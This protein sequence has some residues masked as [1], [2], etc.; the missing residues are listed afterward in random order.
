MTHYKSAASVPPGLVACVE[1]LALNAHFIARIAPRFSF[2]RYDAE[3]RD[4]D[5]S[6]KCGLWAI[7][8]EYD[9]ERSYLYL[10]ENSIE[11]NVAMVPMFPLS[12]CVPQWDN[13]N[14]TYFD[15]KPYKPYKVCCI[16]QNPKLE[17]MKGGCLV[18]CM[19]VNDCTKDKVV[20]MPN[21]QMPPPCCFSSNRVGPCDNCAGA[22]GAPTGNPKMAFAFF[23]QPKDAQGFVEVAQQVMSR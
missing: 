4:L 11:T 10:R 6:E 9:L 17:V 14:V 1:L 16:Q 15:R 22:C 21:E 12:I 2:D 5:C 8:H 13:T 20:I 7:C 19:K 23:P 3:L 18:A